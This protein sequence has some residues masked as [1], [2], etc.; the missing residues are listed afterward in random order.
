MTDPLPAAP[1]TTNA[2]ASQIEPTKR[3]RAPAH[4]HEQERADVRPP[5]ADLAERGRAEEASE[6]EP[7]AA[8]GHECAEADVSGVECLLREHDLG[9]VDRGRPDERDVPDDEHG[10]ERRRREDEP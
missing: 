3:S 1:P 4:S 9:D 2:T 5:E 7:D 10:A 8:R 6:R